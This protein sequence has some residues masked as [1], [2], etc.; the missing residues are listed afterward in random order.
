MSSTRLPGKTLMDLSG[1]PMIDHVIERARA[2]RFADELWIATT[3]D[4]TD[5]VL[6]QHLDELAVPY[7]RGS[8]EDVLERYCQVAEA[9]AA[10]TIVR[11]TCDCPLIDPAVIDETI[12]AFRSA[13]EVDYCSNI[14]RRTYPIGMDTEVF[15]R[16]ALERAHAEATLP[17][18]R[19][20][21]TPYLYQHPDLFRLR[22]VEAPA[23]GTWPDLRL[24]V[25]ESADLDLMRR[26]ICLATTETNL[27][28]LID[29]LHDHSELVAVNADVIH[30]HV[31][32]P[33]GWSDVR[34]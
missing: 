22:N 6:A 28:S 25:D 27:Q 29:V 19:E 26:L 8:L 9:A 11:I 14:L 15:S 18:E 31:D 34:S 12:G 5:D 10:E 16:A 17:H 33:A 21:V 7:L 20:H 23:W 3:I 2:S 24:T 1:K 4:A 13:P 32:W 30:R